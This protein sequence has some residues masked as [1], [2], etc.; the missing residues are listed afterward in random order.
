MASGARAAR[1]AVRA[2]TSCSCPSTNE[3]SCS[4]RTVT[5]VSPSPLAAIVA[6]KAAANS[7]DACSTMRSSRSSAGSPVSPSSPPRNNSTLSGS[8]MPGVVIVGPPKAT[9]SAC[10]MPASAPRRTRMMFSTSRIC[11]RSISFGS[12]LDSSSSI[13]V[14]ASTMTGSTGPGGGLSPPVMKLIGKTPKLGKAA[15][16]AKSSKFMKVLK[17]GKG[18]VALSAAIAVI[19]LVVGMASAQAINKQLKKDKAVLNKHI[20]EA[21]AEI[22]ELQSATREAEGL[23][24]SLLEDS[25]LGDLEHDAAIAAYLGQQSPCDADGV[26]PDP[27]GR[28]GNPARLHECRP[29]RSVPGRR[30]PGDRAACRAA[31]GRSRRRHGDRSHGLAHAERTRAR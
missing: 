5:T 23:V 9:L 12:G 15:T 21:D 30:A 26:L 3:V 13:V 17:F 28:G 27:G 25:E 6:A 11:V 7:L 2:A 20:D 31:G 10:T 22:A 16:M 19:E 18:A 29:A 8:A 1:L 4:L 24:K 14:R